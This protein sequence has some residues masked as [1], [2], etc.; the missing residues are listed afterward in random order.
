MPECCACSLSL[1][2]FKSGEYDT[3]QA[4]HNNKTPSASESNLSLVLGL[5][6]SSVSLRGTRERKWDVKGAR[7][8]WLSA[9]FSIL[10]QLLI[11]TQSD[12]VS[13]VT[14][15][16]ERETEI[17]KEISNKNYTIS[18]QIYQVLFSANM[19]DVLG[20]H[21]HT[22]TDRHSEHTHLSGRKIWSRSQI[23]HH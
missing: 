15:Y 3:G 6:V 22:H 14:K 20:S 12:W 16:G 1:P 18:V 21:T 13:W 17:D 23:A 7:M 4:H 11:H 8:S 9:L 19:I 5:S 10:V 2:Y